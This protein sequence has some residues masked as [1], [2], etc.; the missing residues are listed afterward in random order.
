MDAMDEL[1]LDPPGPVRA[2]DAATMAVFRRLLVNTLLTRGHQL[3]PVVRPDVLGLPG[4]PVGR[5][6]RSHRRCLQHLV[7]ADRAVLRHV[8][9]P[10]PQAQR[11]DAVDGGVGGVLRRGH[12]S[13]SWP[14]TPTACCAC[15][16]PGSGCSSAPRC[17]GPWPG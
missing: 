12:R 2:P 16:A 9:R 6:H 3:V 8:R 4:N 13:S 10:A 15:A 14:S 17:S 11:H 7:G 1:R 5:R